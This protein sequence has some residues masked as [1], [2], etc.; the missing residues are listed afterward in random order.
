MS[1]STQCVY[2]VVVYHVDCTAQLDVD[3]GAM[4]RSVGMPVAC[5]LPIPSSLKCMC[6]QAGSSATKMV[7][8]FGAG[9]FEILLYGGMGL[10][11]KL[12]ERSSL[13]VQGG[14]YSLHRPNGHPSNSVL[15]V[16][17]KTSLASIAGMADVEREW[18]VGRRLNFLAEADGS[19]PGVASL[20]CPS[21]QHHT[22]RNWP[23][24]FGGGHVLRCFLSKPQVKFAFNPAERFA[25]LRNLTKSWVMCSIV[26]SPAGY[27]QSPCSQHVE[28][29]C[30]REGPGQAGC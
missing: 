28:Q 19:L 13:M 6:C 16:M 7:H 27:V 12:V 20:P 1:T 25:K 14:I 3:L 8:S 17:Y 23:I 4:H 11:G 22:S 30:C 10:A 21:S 26:I 5:H 9:H 15:K 24:I 18:E 2:P 29:D